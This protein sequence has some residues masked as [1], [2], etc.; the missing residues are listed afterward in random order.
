MRAKLMLWGV[1]ATLALGST[2]ALANVVVV[3]SHRSVGQGYPPGKTL[4]EIGQDPAEGGDVVTVIGPA[5]A[6]TFRGPGNFDAKQVQ[7]ASAAGQRGRFGALRASEVAHNPS[8]WDVDVSQS[9]KVCVAEVGKL[10]AVA[11]GQRSRSDRQHPRRGRQDRGS[12]LGCGQ[13]AGRLADGAADRRTTRLTRSSGPIRARR[14]T[15]TSSPF[16]SR[17]RPMWSAL[18]RC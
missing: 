9:G 14:A 7:L 13:G 6:Q 8:I 5:S 15:S 4:P 3:K 10:A 2:A 1:A 12:E 18:P 11:S 16:R 17:R